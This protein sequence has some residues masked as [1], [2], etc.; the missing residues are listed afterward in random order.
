MANYLGIDCNCISSIEELEML[1]NNHI[2]FTPTVPNQ[3]YLDTKKDA[4]NKGL[5]K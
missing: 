2:S 3:L 4:I 1:I 5:N